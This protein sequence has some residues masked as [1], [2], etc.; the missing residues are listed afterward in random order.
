MQARP[1]DHTSPSRLTSTNST[2]F[3]YDRIF[4]S[5]SVSVADPINI[6]T[7][8]L[9]RSCAFSVISACLRIPLLLTL[10]LQKNR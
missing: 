3:A 2:A 5:C 10:T 7:I 9:D 6:D 4:V 8:T 1:L